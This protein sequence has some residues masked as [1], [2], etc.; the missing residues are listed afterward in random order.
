MMVLSG[1]FESEQSLVILVLAGVFYDVSARAAGFPGLVYL[2]VLLYNAALFLVWYRIDPTEPQGYLSCISITLLWLTQTQGHMMSDR[3]KQ[4]LRALAVVLAVITPA[5]RYLM[6]RRTLVAFLNLL[7]T[8]MILGTLGI[9]LR[10]RFF[11]Y[12][13]IAI[14]GLDLGVFVLDRSFADR[15][16]G[17]LVLLALG[18]GLLFLAGTFEKRRNLVTERMKEIQKRLSGWE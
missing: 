14:I 16:T 18:V 7:V 15:T 2:A 8:G 1:A 3:V 5:A 17:T 12:A 9:L 10:V 13:G 6:G 11:L 4:S